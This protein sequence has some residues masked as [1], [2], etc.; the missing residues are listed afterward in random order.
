LN[1]KKRFLSWGSYYALAVIKL[2][3][4]FQAVRQRTAKPAAKSR[5]KAKTK[6]TRSTPTR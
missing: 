4:H 5:A 2:G 1:T 6:P 3:E